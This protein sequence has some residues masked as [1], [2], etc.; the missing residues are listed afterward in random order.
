MV[1][2][3]RGAI[4]DAG[5][6]LGAVIGIGTDFTACT[7]LPTL[8]DGTPL[9]EVPGS[10]GRRHADAKLW[11]HAFTD[12]ALTGDYRTATLTDAHGDG[13][14]IIFGRATPWVQL[15]TPDWADEQAV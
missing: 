10:A 11:K 14:R 13:C 12:I 8:A 7:V 15:W 6:D 3:V 9:C 5:A 1:A 2:A 4:G